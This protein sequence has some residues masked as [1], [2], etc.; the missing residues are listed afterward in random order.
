MRDVLIFGCG[1]VVGAGGLYALFALHRW[2][3]SLSSKINI[4]KWELERY[5]M[6][7]ELWAEFQFWKREQKEKK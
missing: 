3:D 1:L 4:L 2:V 7:R 6:E 5:T